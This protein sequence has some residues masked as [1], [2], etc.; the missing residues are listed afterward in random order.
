MNKKELVDKVAEQAALSLTQADR[1][2]K[3]ITDVVTKELAGGGN[4][5]LTG[6]GVF[7][8]KNRSERL[9]RNPKTGESIKIAAAK[10]P[11]FKAGKGLKE[12]VN[13]K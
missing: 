9:G 2:I 1:A 12:A 5:T 8:V 13:G 4:V 3:S 10:Q 6:F 11:S 7:Q